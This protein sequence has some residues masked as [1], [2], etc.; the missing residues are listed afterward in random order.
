[1]MFTKQDHLSIDIEE[2]A[3]AF[4]KDAHH[5]IKVDVV[6]QA[7]YIDEVAQAL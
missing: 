6:I 7:G 5:T 1:M 2:E 3:Q 4:D